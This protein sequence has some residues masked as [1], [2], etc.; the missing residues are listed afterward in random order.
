[1]P[2]RNPMANVAITIRRPRRIA[3]DDMLCS[4][5]TSFPHIG[6]AIFR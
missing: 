4:P 3:L 6:T 1:L 2:I 5:P